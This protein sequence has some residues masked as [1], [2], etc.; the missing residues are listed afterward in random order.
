VNC[1]GHMGKGIALQFKQAFPEN[2][3]EY[4]KACKGGEVQPGRMFVHDTGSMIS[5]RFIINFPTK[6][7]WRGKSRMEDID[8]GLEALVAEVRRL[9]ITSIAVPP[10]GCGYGGLEWT[11]VRPKIEE[12][13]AEVPDVTV[14]LYAPQAAPEAAARPVKTPKPKMTV[15]RALFICLMQQYTEL[16][17]RLSQLEI[18]K[19][20]YFIQESGEP[21]RL[22]YEAGLYGPYADNLNKVLELLEGHFIQGYSGSRKP[23]VA[24]TVLP[25]AV[26]EARAFLTNHPDSSQRLERTAEIIEGFET[27]YGMELLSSAHW[28]AKHK[29]PPATTADEAINAFRLW[30]ERKA[31]LFQPEHIC[32][33]WERLE[34]CGWLN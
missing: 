15:A 31:R 26:E 24:L 22:R 6:R 3:A 33:A 12:A 27:P 4:A 9:G 30:N 19:L 32:T 10:L 18:Q 21:L 2:F 25:G 11:E 14:L 23:D 8:A 28:V 29:E 7:H 17:Y 5:P 1:V 13:F 34:S 16:S 20:A